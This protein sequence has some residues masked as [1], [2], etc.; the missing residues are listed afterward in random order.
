MRPPQGP[1][2][3]LTHAMDE[4]KDALD[5]ADSGWPD[6]SH[7]KYVVYALPAEQT[8]WNPAHTYLTPVGAF[9]GPVQVTYTLAL[10]GEV[11]AVVRH[12]KKENC[13]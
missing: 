10:N 12:A 3:Q 11:S 2:L 5:R 1:P 4:I 7:D 8:A 9:T 13:A 6:N